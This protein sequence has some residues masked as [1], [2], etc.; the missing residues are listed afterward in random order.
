[1]TDPVAEIIEP[2]DESPYAEEVSW[3]IYPITRRI[4]AVMAWVLVACAI[5]KWVLFFV[6]MRYYMTEWL[7]PALLVVN[8][9]ILVL[10]TLLA[11]W[12]VRVL[13]AGQGTEFL[14]L[15]SV[16]GIFYCAVVAFLA[17]MCQSWNAAEILLSPI[18]HFAW[19][20]ISCFAFLCY[21]YTEGYSTHKRKFLL[22]LVLIVFARSVAFFL[23]LDYGLDPRLSISQSAE[24]LLTFIIGPLL[25]LY[26]L[27]FPLCIAYFAMQLALIAPRIISMP[28]LHTT[29]SPP[30]GQE[31]DRT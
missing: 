29:I 21:K 13:L 6:G 26:H 30:K 3:H 10:I 20:F 5:A 25:L 8:C 9:A 2:E 23:F 15:A 27:L 17:K 31:A 22:I 7:D 11:N 19:F 4:V 1:M 28:R 24:F 14:R 18:N 16:L 12:C